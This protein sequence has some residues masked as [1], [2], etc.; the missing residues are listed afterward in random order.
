M[1]APSGARLAPVLATPA[2]VRR[3]AAADDC[4]AGSSPE[5]LSRPCTTP[6]NQPGRS[7]SMPA[8]PLTAAAAAAAFGGQGFRAARIGFPLGSPTTEWLRDAA[9]AAEQGLRGPPQ[10]APG[11]APNPA[12]MPWPAEMPHPAGASGTDQLCGDGG[13]GAGEGSVREAGDAQSGGGQGHASGTGGEHPG[14]LREGAAAHGQ[15][16]E[17]G[18]PPPARGAAA[19]H[20][21]EEP[22]GS[23]S[24]ARG[25]APGGKPAH[26]AAAGGAAPP[27]LDPGPKPSGNPGTGARARARPSEDAD[28]GLRPGPV[29]VPIVLCMD[30]GD[31][32][33]LVRAR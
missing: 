26:T 25:G 12:P 7:R 8:S 19:L 14:E 1:L 32:A 5:T 17:A 31:H 29:F 9:V 24:G 6:G 27:K 10:S 28:A 20:P 33:L 2:D 21:P 13:E 23:R 22:A 4:L 16:S 3:R 15:A 11:P 18:A 30:E